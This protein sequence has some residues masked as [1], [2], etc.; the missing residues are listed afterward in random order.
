MLKIN[1]ET[2]DAAAQVAVNGRTVLEI[3]VGEAVPLDDLHAEVRRARG[4]NSLVS[5][6]QRLAA[7]CA[8]DPGLRIG[9]HVNKTPD[10]KRAAFARGL[11][12]GLAGRTVPHGAGPDLPP[13]PPEHSPAYRTGYDA[14]AGLR[15]AGRMAA[16]A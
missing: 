10:A 5:Q 7:F 9:D 14:G 4:A 16:E 8:D 15:R 6:V 13:V 1:V 11:V 3:A 2:T 12:D